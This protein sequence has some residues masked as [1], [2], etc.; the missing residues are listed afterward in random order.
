MDKKWWMESIGYQIYP[1]SFFDSNDDGIGD[2]NGIYQKLEYLK[3]L[4]VNLIWICPF[5]DSPMDDNGYDVRNFF[6]VAKEFGTMDDV[7]KLI[8]KAHQL[9]IK[10]IL[11]FVLNHTSD[12][13]PWFIESRSSVDNP[14]RDYYIWHEGRQ[15]DGQKI[16]PTNW[17]S[18]FG[19]SCWKYDE[20]TDSYYM[21]IFQTKCLI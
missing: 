3:D 16:E 11:D 15:K 18:F 17:G 13:H 10:I 7:N 14:Y 21:K 4:G 2:L 6:D 1:K 5:Y 8:E 9:G 19:G 12:E 20:P